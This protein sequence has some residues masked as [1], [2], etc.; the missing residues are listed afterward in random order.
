MPSRASTPSSTPFRGLSAF[1]VTPADAQGRVEA[2]ALARLVRRLAEAGVDSIGLLGSTGTYAYLSRAERRRAIEA[3]R[4]AA[5]KVPLIVGAGALRTDEAVALALDAEAAGADGLLLAPVSYTPLFDEEVFEH[6]RAVG[7]ATALPLCIYNNPSTTHFSFG[8]A[9]LERLAALPGIVALKQPAPPPEEAA[10]RHQALRTRLPE[11]FA[12]G[13]SGDWN[14]PAS[15]LAGGAAWYSV[16]G[17]LLPVQALA[18]MRAAQ[19]GDV[20]EVARLEAKLAPLWA[21][22]RQFGS[23]RVVYA[24]AGLLGLCRAEPP[25]PILPLAEAEHGRLRA[26]LDQAGGALG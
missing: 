17:G 15:V 24:A 9:L 13:Y 21:L 1:P 20:A 25:R 22:F 14:A 12:L 10:A 2:G 4:E 5:G 18:L 16:L 19:A 11:G 8:E 26:A 7:T 3:A 23:L 6:F